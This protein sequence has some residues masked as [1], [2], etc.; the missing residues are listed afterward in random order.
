MNVDYT[1]K[2]PDYSG[3]FHIQYATY[4]FTIVAK[5]ALFTFNG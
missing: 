2:P 5:V 1:K 3:G 4:F